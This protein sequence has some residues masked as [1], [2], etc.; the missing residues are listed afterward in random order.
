MRPGRVSTPNAVPGMMRPDATTPDAI[1]RIQP[2]DAKGW[3]P[4]IQ[5]RV[6]LTRP[7]KV[8]ALT[9]ALR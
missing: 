6:E 1:G 9:D 3:L 4:K 5:V 8:A 2:F 7:T